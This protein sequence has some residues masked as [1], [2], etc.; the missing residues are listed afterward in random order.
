[1][2]RWEASIAALGRAEFAEFLSEALGVQKPFHRIVAR[3]KAGDRALLF[4]L[5]QRVPE[6]SCLSAE[7]KRSFP[8]ELANA[9]ALGPIREQLPMLRFSPC[10]CV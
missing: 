9:D 7:R 8:F 2:L 3:I 5:K 1:M 10:G 6:P 4:R